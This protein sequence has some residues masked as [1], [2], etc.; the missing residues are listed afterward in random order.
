MAS[1]GCLQ[2]ARYFLVVLNVIFFVLGLV[3]L[4][5]GLWVLFDQESF[6]T[7]IVSNGVTGK[8]L[9]NAAFALIAVGGITVVLST[10]GCVGTGKRIKCVL[11]LYLVFIMLLLVAQ[12][13]LGLLV[14]FEKDKIYPTLNSTILSTFMAYGNENSSVSKNQ[15]SMWDTI[16][17]NF[18]CC[19]YND[20]KDWNI[21]GN[22]KPE[23]R[24]PC[25]CMKAEVQ[26]KEYFCNL[27][28]S[29]PPP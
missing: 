17:T 2:A 14:Y 16:Q 20:Y 18:N 28:I 6:M 7:I 15:W 3:I 12:V 1:K 9:Q 5:Y 8:N 11:W 27:T 4:G 19:G 10:L 13:V 26:P 23:K 24:Y 25:T 21:N 29:A 22:V